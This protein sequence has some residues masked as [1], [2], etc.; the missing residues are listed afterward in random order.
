M[1]HVA[2]IAS[3]FDE[4]FWTS[5]RF[6]RQAGDERLDTLS[7]L[8][9]TEDVDFP[10]WWSTF[11]VRSP[12]LIGWRGGPRAMQLLQQTKK[13]LEESA[14][15]SLAALL[16]MSPTTLRRRL[17]SSRIHDW[18]NDAFSRGA[19][20]Y[21]RVGGDDAAKRLAR[22]VERTLLFAGEAADAE[23]RNGTVHGAIGSGRRAAEQVIGWR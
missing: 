14:I 21:P 16:S 23:G 2:R 4:P 5:E 11:S 6:A 12:L 3:E 22:P 20:S 13:G 10:V 17:V 8:Q 9:G 19:Y 7:F 15:R 1:G 18:T